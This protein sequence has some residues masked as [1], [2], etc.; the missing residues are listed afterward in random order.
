M[1]HLRHAAHGGSLRVGADAGQAEAC[2]TSTLASPGSRGRRL[3]AWN[4]R[5]FFS[6]K[7]A[8]PGQGPG[9]VGW[10]LG[11][12]VNSSVERSLDRD[13]GPGQRI[14]TAAR[15]FAEISTMPV[16][17]SRATSIW[18]A[19]I[20]RAAKTPHDA[21]RLVTVQGELRSFR[22]ACIPIGRVAMDCRLESSAKTS[23]RRTSSSTPAL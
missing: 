5:H 11:R 18:P 3:E 4:R 14:A 20:T 12:R 22:R 9:V 23:S 7:V 21:S 6:G 16:L 10:R 2:E 17:E 15:A 19:T 1:V 13:S 8:G